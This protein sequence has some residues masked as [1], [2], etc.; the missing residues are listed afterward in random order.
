MNYKY[1]IFA[2]FDEIL[3]SNFGYFKDEDVKIF[4][5]YSEFAKYSEY[6]AKLGH[7]ELKLYAENNHIINEGTKNKTIQ[8]F[9]NPSVTV[10]HNVVDLL[11]RLY[12]RGKVAVVVS[13]PTKYPRLQILQQIYKDSG[14]ALGL[15]KF[16][17]L[18]APN[19]QFEPEPEPE[20]EQ[21]PAEEEAAVILETEEESKEPE[22]EPEENVFL[23]KE[24]PEQPK[25]QPQEE[26]RALTKEDLGLGE[27]KQEEP[28]PE[29][30]EENVFLRKQEPE[31]AEEPAPQ[32]HEEAVEQEEAAIILEPQEEEQEPEQPQEESEN[33]VFLKKG[34]E[35]PKQESE[36]PQEEQEEAEI[37]LEPG[38]DHPQEP[39][40]EEPEESSNDEEATQEVQEEEQSSDDEGTNKKTD[41]NE[42]G[43]EATIDFDF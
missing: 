1:V 35:A 13:D 30:P 33:N 32:S 16:S 19:A 23:R 28:A 9:G 26:H 18:F 29:E 36:A 25:E 39:A 11:L 22:P 8:A 6:V 4:I 10:E 24:Q 21:E 20:P 27:P 31:K 38:E 34:E 12:K 3:K 5:V 40:P 41:E 2:D 7:E 14:F 42:D 37:V 17:V 15:D 43:K